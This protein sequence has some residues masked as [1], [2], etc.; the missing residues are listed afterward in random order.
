MPSRSPRLRVLAL[1]GVAGLLGP[2]V[3]PAL[4]E[5]PFVGPS[6]AR[7]K[8]DVTF[9][10]ADA[11]EGR[12]PGTKGIEASADYIASAFKEAGL[13]SATGADGYFQPFTIRAE[14]VLTEPPRLAFVGPEGREIKPG[15]DQFRPLAIGGSGRLEALPVVFVGYGITAKDSSKGLDY[16]DYAGVDVRGKVALILRGE[17]QLD[18]E[19]SVFAGTQTT[20]HARFVVKAENA[21]KHGAAGVLFVNDRAGLKAMPDQVLRVGGAGSEEVAAIPFVMTTRAT[22]DRLL[23]ASG[24]PKLEVLE[25]D[26]DGDLKPRSRPLEG[27]TMTASARIERKG[28]D[29]KNVVGVLE[30]SG[31][32]AEETIVVGAHY[33]HLGNGGFASGSLAM[34]S[35]S[36]HNG[37][38]DNAS[39]TAMIMELA[40]RLGKR[41]DP[42][43]RRVVFIAFSGEEKGLLG[44]MHYVAHPLI[45]LARTILMV[46]F[47]MVGRLNAESELTM[48]GT[49]STPGLEGLV[50]A[51]GKGDGFK[52][53]NIK[54]MTD[55]F[56]G[57]DHL[58]FYLKKVPVLFPFTGVHLDY[59]R[60]SDDT[61]RINFPG[62]ARIADLAELLLLDFARRQVRPEWAGGDAPATDPHAG[63]VLEPGRTGTGAYLGTM[64]DYGGGENGLK[65]ADVRENG[66]AAKAGLKGGD[67]IIGFGGKPVANVNDYTTLLYATKPGDVVD[68][69][70]KRDGKEMTLKVTIGTRSGQ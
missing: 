2:M 19:K 61:E 32:Q 49:G 8:R 57:S 13:R 65:L 15:S 39:G 59:H 69:V 16:D 48:I 46:N 17:P 26:I 12:A 68:V 25:K 27:W 14:P 37:A 50:D 30:G 20:T 33:D 22:V 67:V 51:I 66:P 60:P 63:G 34:F 6:E 10:A 11:Q 23:E 53:K 56:G 21:A 36:I 64:P 40:R 43:P 52:I 54:G 29:T 45:P 9:L 7:L 35:R 18:D 55:G 41:V 3:A 28:L 38:D 1:A 31:P 24:Q 4:G 70:F 62:M 47:D 58:S 5:G 42:L 44:S